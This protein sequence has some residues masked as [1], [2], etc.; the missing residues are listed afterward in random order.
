MNVRLQNT[1]SEQPNEPDPERWNLDEVDVHIPD[2][3]DRECRLW[4]HVHEDHIGV[5]QREGGLQV[6]ALERDARRHADCGARQIHAT[7]Q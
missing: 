3:R 5:K 4:E 1:K 6:R 2:M 7:L